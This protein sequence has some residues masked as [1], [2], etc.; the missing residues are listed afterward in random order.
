M[1]GTA[2]GNARRSLV[3]CKLLVLGKGHI[4]RAGPSYMNKITRGDGWK[5][6]HEI[7]RPAL[8]ASIQQKHRQREWPLSVSSLSGTS[9]KQRCNAVVQPTARILRPPPSTN[10]ERR[11]SQ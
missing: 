2:A 5:H 4:C 10:L 9:N 3:D 11:I 1:T 7:G 8:A 6:Q